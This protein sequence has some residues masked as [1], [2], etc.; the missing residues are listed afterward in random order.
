MRAEMN[1]LAKQI[2]EAAGATRIFVGVGND[3]LMGGCVMGDS[4]E[5][6]VVDANLNAFGHPN[7]FICDASVF[8]SSAGSQPSQTIIALA[9]R[10]GDHLVRRSRGTNE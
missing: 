2:L 4:P 10:L 7:L 3:H 5:D 1:N 8:P 9:S 6:S